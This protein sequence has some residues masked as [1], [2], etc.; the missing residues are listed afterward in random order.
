MTSSSAPTCPDGPAERSFWARLSQAERTAF[1]GAARERSAGP[2]AVLCEEGSNVA[3]VTV[4][5]SGW[6]K[7]S[8][9]VD[10]RERI[11]AVRGP[12]DIV[13]ERA[14]LMRR[15][16][17][18]TVAALGRLTGLVVPANRFQE[19]VI[20]HP[21]IRAVL[22]V[23]ERERAAE[24]DQVRAGDARGV[25]HRLAH[26]LRELARRVGAP[27]PA[28]TALTLPMSRREVACWVDAE[29][30]E[31]NRVLAAWA[32]RGMVVTARRNLTVPDAGLLDALCRA[33]SEP[34][35]W[36]SLTCSILYVDVASFSSPRRTESDRQ[37]VRDALY[38]T[39]R[40]AFDDSGVSWR[41]CYHEDRGDGVLVVVP[42]D[43]PAQAV[44]DPTL[45]RFAAELRRHNRRSSDALRI[46]VRAA[47]HAGPVTRDREG[48]NADAVIHAA[49]LLD[50]PP[51]RE[52]L[53][54]SGADLAFLASDHVFDTALRNDCGLMDHRSF[55]RVGFR[56]KEAEF[57]GWMHLFGRDEAVTV[58]Q[59][60][61][62]NRPET[63]HGTHFHGT[64]H[65]A[66]DFVLGNKK[67]G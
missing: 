10:G 31:V 16:R 20:D 63:S 40:R 19:L 48:L 27:T 37:A 32:R 13:G 28:G 38:A 58:A 44:A 59:P 33:P 1:A 25:E 18:A 34:P 26:L 67:A 56:V 17:S 55:T 43:V 39:M 8:A 15:S 65:V 42:P 6:A 51:L 46:Q 5:T 14:A 60:A 4:I 52:A 12:G 3:D 21:G 50:A 9:L 35:A 24:E 41:G 47:L 62:E 64:V 61:P 29:T 2:G 7:V 36:S 49:R 22:D 57:S 54:A 30:K 11:V 53:R 23:Q 66:G 45:P